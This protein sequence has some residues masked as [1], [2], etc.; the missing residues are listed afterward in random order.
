MHRPFSL[1]T[2]PGLAHGKSD[3]PK[4]RACFY[5]PQQRAIVLEALKIFP[6]VGKF[7]RCLG[8][9]IG[10]S[11]GTIWNMAKAKGIELIRVDRRWLNLGSGVG[12][13]ALDRQTGTLCGSEQVVQ[14]ARYQSLGIFPCFRLDASQAAAEALGQIRTDMH[15]PR[16]ASRLLLHRRRFRP[17]R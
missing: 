3:R 16:P 6:N 14:C 11:Y 9:R 13:I 8:K 17:M 15:L 10:V 5:A 1:P 4:T 7:Y 12:K 2:C